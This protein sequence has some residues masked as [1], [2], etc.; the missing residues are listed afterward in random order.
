M[1]KKI[2][3]WVILGITFFFIIIVMLFNNSSSYNNLVVNEN[4]W[5]DLIKDKIDST[6]I[7]I[8]NIKFN[9]YSLLIDELE[10]T[11]YYS[12][13]DSTSKF[14]PS[15]R[16]DVDDGTK[17]VINQ[18]ITEENVKN[19]FN[20]KIMIYNDTKYHI[21][22]LTV[23][24]LP[25]INIIY[26]DEIEKTNR[27]KAN[28]YL[29]D[30]RNNSHKKVINSKISL[31]IIDNGNEKKDYSFS[32]LLDSL[33]KNERENNLSI[34]GMQKHS[35]YLLNSMTD[36]IDKVR[37][38]FSTNLWNNLS[39]SKNENSD[40]VEVFINNHYRGLYS[41]GYNIEK[42][43]LML[44][45]DEFL[46][47][48]N[49][50]IDS[51]KNY[52]TNNKISG[53]KLYNDFL[54]EQIKENS[55]KRECKNCPKLNGFDELKNYYEN[56]L[57]NDIE[58]I[59]K[60]SNIDNAIDIYLYYLFIQADGNVNDDTFNNTYLLL[61]RSRNG[62]ISEY[63]PWNVKYSFG[64]T[65]DDN[66]KIDSSSNE[67]VMKYNPVTILLEIGD[68]DTKELVKKRYNMIRKKFLSEN[69]IN[70]TVDNYEKKLFLSGAF[71]RDELK[72]NKE[73]LNNKE[74]LN[75]FRNYVLER[76]KYM[77][78]YINNI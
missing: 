65:I 64:K 77:D 35:E 42:E 62:Y 52:N 46:F 71:L 41:L 48:K 67:Y 40:Y 4:K 49:E 5:N 68:N 28:I 6:S 22:N 53:Y 11:I 29:F 23:T 54:Q 59:K 76:L 16:Y 13:L 33:G 8:K 25:I 26:D 58:K 19:N 43:S 55:L 69:F 75:E 38:V 36:D 9:D 37:R 74:N 30:N 7:K 14:N 1:N 45:K 51:E 32:M 31:N 20:F 66:K 21:Y 47:F 78:E 12:M 15:I 39:F 63:I 3:L 57:S 73:S 56:L 10:N 34:F 72:W 44:N 17:L 50:F 2:L 60:V 24:T 18:K 70:N 61:R 27:I